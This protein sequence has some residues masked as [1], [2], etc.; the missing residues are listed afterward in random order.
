LRDRLISQNDDESDTHH[1]DSDG[2]REELNPS[3]DSAYQVRATNEAIG[4]FR[5]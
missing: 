3:D 1:D 5:T 4:T 2:F